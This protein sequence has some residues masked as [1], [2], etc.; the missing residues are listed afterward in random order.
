LSEYE[1]LAELRYR[2]RDTWTKKILPVI[3]PGQSRDDIPLSFLPSIAD[4]Y[5]ITSLSAA[6][7]ADLLK[8]LL[9]PT[10]PPAS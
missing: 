8:V 4:Y 1:R 2:D 9:H 7:A 6:G 5:E 10:A 3:L